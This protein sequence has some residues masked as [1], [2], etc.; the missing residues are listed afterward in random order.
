MVAIR[1]GAREVLKLEPND[2]RRDRSASERLARVLSFTLISGHWE[3]VARNTAGAIPAV[4]A[5][6]QPPVGT[7]QPYRAVGDQIAVRQKRNTLGAM[8][9]Q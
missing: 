3:R 6:S 5:H 8:R 9:P 1:T 2:V 7:G 4:D